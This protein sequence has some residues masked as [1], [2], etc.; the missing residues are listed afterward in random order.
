[1]SKVLARQ[2]MSAGEV[3]RALQQALPNSQVRVVS[4][5]ALRVGKHP[6]TATVRINPSGGTTTFRVSG[7]GLLLIRIANELMTVP[8]VRRA[9]GRAFPTT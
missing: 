3:Q 5:S 8:K 4:D 1:V 7:E 9:L 2:E 6:F